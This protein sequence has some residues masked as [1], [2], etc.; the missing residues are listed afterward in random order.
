MAE[1]SPPESHGAV[2]IRCTDCD[3]DGE[4]VEV[5]PVFG[6]GGSG[7]FPEDHVEECERCD[8]TGVEPCVYCGEKTSVLR[9]TDGA[10]CAECNKEEE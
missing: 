6:H 10:C 9:T 3:G 2:T 1:P 4:L 8:G 5:R 7:P